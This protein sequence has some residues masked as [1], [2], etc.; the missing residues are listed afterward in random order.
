MLRLRQI[1]IVVAAAAVVVVVS[2]ILGAIPHWQRVLAYARS[3][4]T[5]PERARAL[6]GA[7]FH[8]V[9]ILSPPPHAVAPLNADIYDL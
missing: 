6:E 8:S 9:A 7:D 5:P 4:G 2:A 3:Q 1:P